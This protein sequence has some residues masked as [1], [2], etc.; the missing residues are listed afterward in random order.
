MYYKLQDPAQIAECLIER[1][2]ALISDKPNAVIG[3]AT[4]STMEPLYSVFLQQFQSNRLDVSR[5]RTFNLDEYIG[6]PAG[7]PQSYRHY[8]QQHLFSGLGLAAGQTCLPDGCCS[9]VEDECARYSAAITAAG[10]LDFQLLGIGTNGH[11]GFN[12]PGTAFDSRTHVVE[13]SENTRIDNSRLFADPAEMPTH[14]ITMGISEIM[15]AR[16]IALVVTGEHK[17]QIMLDL[18]NSPAD[19]LLPASV[20]KLHP[21]V[22]VYLDEA[23]ASLLP[24]GACQRG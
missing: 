6:L 18:Y 7:H 14:A 12:E 13:L 5:L 23:A 8:M 3:L 17:A 9:N 20:L 2:V 24:A 15:G 22:R 11:I 10:G 16:E 21:N 1:V 19:P 4:G